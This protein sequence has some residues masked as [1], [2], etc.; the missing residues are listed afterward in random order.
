VNTPV[1]Q[2]GIDGEFTNSNVLIVSAGLGYKF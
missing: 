1:N 2:N